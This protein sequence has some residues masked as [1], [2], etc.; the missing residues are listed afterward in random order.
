MELA[1]TTLIHIYLPFTFTDTLIFIHVFFP[2][3]LF[4]FPPLQPVRGDRPVGPRL[5]QQT[6]PFALLKLGAF[7]SIWETIPRTSDDVTVPPLP[8]IADISAR[9]E[10]PRAPSTRFRHGSFLLRR[11]AQPLT[12]PRQKS[13]AHLVSNLM[14]AL[15]PPRTSTFT[16]K[17]HPFSP[18]HASSPPRPPGSSQQRPP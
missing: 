14:R 11:G 9:G 8:P 13:F 15:L 4:F 2:T 3:P 5:H 7:S 18:D 12:R 6:L 10:S 1:K 17:K 16:I